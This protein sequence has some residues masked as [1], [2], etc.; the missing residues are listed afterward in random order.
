VA[1]VATPGTVNMCTI[2]MSWEIWP[3]YMR[4]EPIAFWSVSTYRRTVFGRMGSMVVGFGSWG[5]RIQS[6]AEIAEV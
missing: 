2:W 6:V 1:I 5:S 4:A 3:E